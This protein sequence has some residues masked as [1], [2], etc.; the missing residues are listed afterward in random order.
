MTFGAACRARRHRSSPMAS[1]V[2]GHGPNA[3]A[4]L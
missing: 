2:M 1:R 4:V 3:R